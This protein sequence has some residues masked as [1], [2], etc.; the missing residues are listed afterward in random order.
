M[1]HVDEGSIH[2]S[3]TLFDEEELAQ[4]ASKIKTIYVTETPRST[5]NADHT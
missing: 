3:P 4:L 5:E 1:V 2:G